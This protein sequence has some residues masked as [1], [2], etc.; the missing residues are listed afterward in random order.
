MDDH[1]IGEFL[2]DGGAYRRGIQNKEFM[3][4]KNFLHIQRNINQILSDEYNHPIVVDPQTIIGVMRHFS[5]SY[6]PQNTCYLNKRV[7]AKLR[8]DMRDDQH[9][10]QIANEWE[11]EQYE[12]LR[13]NED[14]L[15]NPIPVPIRTE[16]VHP[17][18]YVE[19]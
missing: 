2:K 17:I 10:I 3:S 11:D 18:Q 12:V 15:Y 19:Y 1:S 6:E 14:T 7:I 5:Y 4:E 9:D 8:N 16:E 13:R